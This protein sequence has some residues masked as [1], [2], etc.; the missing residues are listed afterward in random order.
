MARTTPAWKCYLDVQR[1]MSLAMAEGFAAELNQMNAV[2]AYQDAQKQNIPVANAP[3]PTA[4]LTIA[5]P[6]PRSHLHHDGGQS[7]GASG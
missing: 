2:R 4:P 7:V 5:R 6:L 3:S 1:I